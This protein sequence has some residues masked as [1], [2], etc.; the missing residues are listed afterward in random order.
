MITPEYAIQFVK[1][2]LGVPFTPFELNENDLLFWLDY[3]NKEFS[4]NI[5]YKT[6]TMLVPDDPNVQTGEKNLFIIPA[7]RPIISVLNVYYTLGNVLVTG[8]PWSFLS[9]PDLGLQ[10]DFYAAIDLAT[11]GLRNSIFTFTYDFYYPNK[12][13][14]T[15]PMNRYYA[16]E[17]EGEHNS[18]LSTIPGEWEPVFLKMY[19]KNVA[20]AIASIRSMYQTFSTPAGEIQLNA[21]YLENLA[22]KIEEE[23][24][25]T[26]DNF[27]PGTIIT[28][29]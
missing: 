19:L 25:D 3:T 1:Q 6:Y 16:I 29:F 2:R 12:I 27:N 22:D 23:L 4:K 8:H 26:F 17:Y 18:D 24:R 5:P 11:L 10:I 15:P 9:S 20:R 14:I 13:R 28:R 7:D 21:E